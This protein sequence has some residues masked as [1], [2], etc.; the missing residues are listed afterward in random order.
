MRKQATVR[1]AFAGIGVASLLALAAPAQA[2]EIPV[3]SIGA[4]TGAAGFAGVVETNGIRMA[5]DEANAKGLLGNA[6]VKLIEGDDATDK[7]QAISLAEQAI[8]RHEVVLSLG[9]T[10]SPNAIAI[11]PVFNEAKT[12]MIS[13]ATSNAITAVGPY[14]F[15]IQMSP[16]ETVPPLV[17]Y[18]TDTAKARKIAIVYDKSN[19]AF[20]EGKG[21]FT[22]AL[23]ASGGTVVAEEAVLSKDT[24]F[25]A[26]ATKLASADIDGVY[27]IALVEQ[28]ANII[29]QL[30]QAGI[31]EKVKF[32]GEQGLASPRL[33]AIGGKAVEGTIFPGQY[34]AGVDRPLNKAFEQ[35]Y[36]A[37]Y[38]AEP[39]FFAAVGYSMGLVA[40]QALKNA[41][42]NPTRDG[43]RD[44]IQSLKDVPVVVGNGLWN[45][46][47]RNGL[48][49]VV[50]TTL[51]DGKMVV[52]Q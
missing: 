48:Y 51:K 11:A 40:L 35:A 46:K 26:L 18:M 28:A 30:K 38:N 42:P 22:E 43:V 50:I 21:I 39:D 34:L 29:I 9:P 23:K 7:G 15:R 44:A 10:I 6:K 3:M 17:K 27:L 12:P 1:S 31:S 5:F 14:V 47:D 45:H 8:K 19:D 16:V 49:G 36:K 32:F 20:V 52:A 41:G 33:S 24:N 13:F 2:Q 37:R 25:V 4:L